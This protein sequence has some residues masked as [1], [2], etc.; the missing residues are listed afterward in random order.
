MRRC[1][2]VAERTDM[3][4]TMKRKKRARNDVGTG[5][6]NA[7]VQP[8]CDLAERNHGFISAVAR[9]IKADHGMAVKP[10]QVRQWLVADEAERIEPRAG[11]GEILI[12][13]AGAAA[14]D[15][16]AK[17]ATRAGLALPV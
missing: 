6:W 12:A 14:L 10:Q 8:F 17:T 4:K 11:M 13:A 5:R 9:W 15:L 7:R 2:T 3:A 1:V 16:E